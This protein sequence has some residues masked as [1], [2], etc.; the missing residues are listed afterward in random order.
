[1]IKVITQNLDGWAKSQIWKLEEFLTIN[2]GYVCP[3]SVS[4]VR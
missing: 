3:F 2:M 1:M 4:A